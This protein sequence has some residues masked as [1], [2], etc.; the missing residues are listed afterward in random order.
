[1]KHRRTERGFHC[2]AAS[3][4]WN[5]LGVTASCFLIAVGI[6][7]MH[8]TFAVRQE[9]QSTPLGP[10]E[11]IALLRLRPDLE[12]QRVSL[13]KAASR[14]REELT[15]LA[16]W[17]PRDCDPTETAQW[18]RER[19]NEQDVVIQRLDHVVSLAGSRVGIEA[20][21]VEV[22]GPFAAL[23]NFIRDLSSGERAIVC[24]QLQIRRVDSIESGG[25]QATLSVR[26]MEANEG[27]VGQRLFFH[28]GVSHGT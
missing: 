12:A 17:L 5:V 6:G 4:R 9:A 15:A 18:I 3:I 22:D 1:M 27:T 24:D 14:Q 19:A 28:G 25:C 20:F 26:G 11:A 8:S 10:G 21:V 13:A 7:L 23:V 2:H 16:K